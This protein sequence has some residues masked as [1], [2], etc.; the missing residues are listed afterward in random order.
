MGLSQEKEWNLVI[1]NGMGGARG[2]YAKWN[3]SVRERQIPYDFAHMWSLRNKT[4]KQKEKEK[5]R[6][7]TRSRLLNIENKLMV[8]GG[9]TGGGM[10]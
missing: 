3:K 2:Y 10:S 4:N 1:C 5:E 7:K 9:Q 6:G 8:P